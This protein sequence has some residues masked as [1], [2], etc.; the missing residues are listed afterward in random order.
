MRVALKYGASAYRQSWALAAILNVSILKCN[1]FINVSILKNDIFLLLSQFDWGLGYIDW[2][3]PR[4][5]AYFH[6][7]TLPP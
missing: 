7:E 3:R 2:P 4:S 6:S 1:I 5:V